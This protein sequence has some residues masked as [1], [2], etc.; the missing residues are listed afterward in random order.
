MKKVTESLY[1]IS[2]GPVNCFIIDHDGLTLIDSGF[3][4]DGDKIIAAIK[5]GGKNPDDLKQI[6]LTHSHPDHSG[7][8]AYLKNKFKIPVYAHEADASLIAKGIAGRLPHVLSPGALNWILFN[9]FIKRG[10]NETVAFQVDELVKDQDFLPFC[11]GIQVIYTPGHSLG[12]IALL[13]KNEG[14]LICGDICSN[15]M[16]LGYSTVYE[17]RKIGVQSILKAASFD[18]ETAVFGHGNPIMASA[19]KTIKARFEGEPA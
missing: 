7:S 8:A 5:K 1:Q 18:F 9:L 11:G 15:M 4:T 2:L 14:V 12:H 6:V 17:D 19:N 10:A 16:G 13:L 3:K